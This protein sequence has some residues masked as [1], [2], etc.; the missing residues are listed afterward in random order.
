MARSIKKPGISRYLTEAK[1]SF[2][3]Y[4]F[5]CGADS[6]LALSREA[7]KDDRAEC[8]EK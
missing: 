3:L 5:S 1:R 7:A 4:R 6:A 8:E 2:S